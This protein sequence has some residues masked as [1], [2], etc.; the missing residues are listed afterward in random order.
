MQGQVIWQ[1]SSTK[2]ENANSLAFISQW[3]SALD[4][5]EI[6]L[7]QRMIPQSGELDELNWE[8]QRFDEVFELKSPQIRGITLYWRKPDS[9]QERN[10]TPHQLVLNTHSQQL[11]ICPQ[12]QKQLVIRVGLPEIIYQT[13]E[14]KNPQLQ[15]SPFGQNHILTLR[16]TQQQLEVKVTLSPDNLSQLKQLLY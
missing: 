1:Q 13:I 14:I 16:D 4:N 2:A 8:L 5:K 3:W 7:A 9:Q 6:T 10:T 15:S 11:Y 12:S